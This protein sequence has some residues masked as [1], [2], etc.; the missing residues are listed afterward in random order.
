M[1]KD[2]PLVSI[3]LPVYN[4]ENYIKEAL[5]S[6]LAQ[7]Y[8]NFELI[9][10]DNASTDKTK[11]ICLNY[12]KK[13]K[14]IRYYR[15]NENLGIEP[16]FNKV[17][18][19]FSGKYCMLAS[20]DD[21]WLPEYISTL[22]RILEDNSDVVLAFSGVQRIDHLGNSIGGPLTTKNSKLVQSTIERVISVINSN[23][24][25]KMYGLMR[26]NILS[27]TNLFRSDLGMVN[28]LCL[29]TELSCHGR[30]DFVSECLF[31][32]RKHSGQSLLSKGQIWEINE[33]TMNWIYSLPNV[34]DDIG[35][36]IEG[37]EKVIKRHN[38]RDS[39]QAKIAGEIRRFKRRNLRRIRNLFNKIILNK[40]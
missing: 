17:M 30:F 13:D 4:G 8:I 5:E 15:N 20:H 35:K 19:M 27:Q 10:S 7:D 9:I 37:F 39:I 24:N 3:G 25:S 2:T 28:D 1:L 22:V 18:K 38:N 36:I 11:N 33:N 34:Q 32:R 29:I 21:L 23:S 40:A 14:R 26:T 16:N 6:L 12:I 31:K